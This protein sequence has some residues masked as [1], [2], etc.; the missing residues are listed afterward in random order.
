G[1]QIGTCIGMGGFGGDGGGFR[2]GER[3]L[4]AFDRGGER[5]AVGGLQRGQF[6]LDLGD[7]IDDARA[8]FALLTRGV[9]ELMALGGQVGEFGGQVGEDLLGGGQFA[10]GLGD[11]G[12]DAAAAA[13]AF[14]RLLAD[15]V[16]LG[17]EPGQRRFGIGGELGLALA[18]GGELLEAQ[19][20][21]G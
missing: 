8:E 12:V 7:L 14:A 9:L 6:A 1:F 4:R 16:F 15:A 17:G 5:A 21:L 20:E 10:V 13:G 3:G 18:V 19:I 11:L 2:L